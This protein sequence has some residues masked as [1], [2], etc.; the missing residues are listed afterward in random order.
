[1]NCHY[2][3]QPKS[4]I[5]TQSS[6]DISYLKIFHFELSFL[7]YL[8]PL[9]RRNSFHGRGTAGEGAIVT[10]HFFLLSGM[11]RALLQLASIIHCKSTFDDGHV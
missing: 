4:L 6:Q 5:N 8:A 2:F 7:H 9:S 11:P 1:M 3:F 10:S